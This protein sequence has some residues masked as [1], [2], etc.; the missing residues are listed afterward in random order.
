MDRTRNFKLTF[1]SYLTPRMGTD[2]FFQWLIFAGNG[3]AFIL[4]NS[5]VSCDNVEFIDRC[6]G[7]LKS[8]IR[9]YRNVWM[10]VQDTILKI[11]AN[12]RAQKH[13]ATQKSPHELI[14]WREMRRVPGREEFEEKWWSGHASASGEVPRKD[15]EILW[16]YESSEIEEAPSETKCGL[17]GQRNQIPPLSELKRTEIE[18][19]RPVIFTLDDNPRWFIFRLFKSPRYDFDEETEEAVREN[20]SSAGKVGCQSS[21]KSI[22]RA[23]HPPES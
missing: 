11:L 8:Q 5:K 14:T 6:H 18:E 2:S 22:R 16:H 3:R 7:V 10:S 9:A 19:I 21:P 12:Y 17:N 4:R 1:R 23:R 15:E 13:Q 20:R